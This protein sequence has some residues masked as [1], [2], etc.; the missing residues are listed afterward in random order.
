MLKIGWGQQQKISTGSLV[1]N[2]LNHQRLVM[3]RDKDCIFALQFRNIVAMTFC[4]NIATK[5]VSA[6][7]IVQLPNIKVGIQLKRRRLGLCLCW[8]GHLM[9]LYKNTYISD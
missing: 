3:A 9:V 6:Y 5:K 4:C 7:V 2:E 8:Y 1:A